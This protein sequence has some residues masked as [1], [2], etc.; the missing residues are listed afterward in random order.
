MD[1][2]DPE[3]S[4]GLLMHKDQREAMEI[5]Q[6]DFNDLKGL[7]MKALANK[8]G[9]L[10]QLNE[11]EEE[12]T[13][14]VAQGIMLEGQQLLHQE[15]INWAAVRP[16]SEADQLMVVDVRTDSPPLL[17]SDSL[18]QQREVVQRGLIQL[19]ELTG[20]PPSIKL[21]N[22]EVIRI[23]DLAVAGGTYSDI[24]QGLWLGE[25][26]VKRY[27]FLVSKW[28]IHKGELG[29]LEGPEKYQGNRLQSPEGRSLKMITF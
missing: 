19:H 20:I 21:M 25:K 17:P 18:E 4:A 6:K 22:G 10:A 9:E 15:P 11:L 28:G 5:Q 26:K 8:G 12:S 29:C 23:G 14:R 24:W 13:A 16:K 7:L 3:V 27:S 2:T 1:T